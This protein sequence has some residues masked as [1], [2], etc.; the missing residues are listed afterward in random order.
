MTKNEH[1]KLSENFA[2][3]KNV[4]DFLQH[5]LITDLRALIIQPGQ[6]FLKFLPVICGIEFLGACYDEM[7]FNSEKV[8][9]SRKRFK[10]GIDLMGTI[11]KKFDGSQ[12]QKHPC[13]YENFRCPMVHQFR[14]DQDRFRLT[15]IKSHYDEEEVRK[16]HLQKNDAAYIIVLEQL[17]DDFAL[18]VKNTINDIQKNLLVIDKLKETHVIIRDMEI[19]FTT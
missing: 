12:K 1:K 7:P 4:A 13:L 11:Y 18:A 8:G 3:P 6:P 15:S 5:F 19:L 9:V 2:E 14:T 10:K 16:W 17:Y